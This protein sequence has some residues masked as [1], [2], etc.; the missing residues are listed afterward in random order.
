MDYFKRSVGALKGRIARNKVA[1]RL[2]RPRRKS[3]QPDIEKKLVQ[4]LSRSRIPSWR[5]LKYIGRFLS[6][7]E[8]MIIGS[9][10][11]VFVASALVVTARLYQNNVVALPAFGGSYTEALTGAPKFINPLY[12]SLSTVDSDI[13]SLVYGGLLKRN[14]DAQLVPDI[15]EHYTVSDDKKTYTFTLR[16]GIRWHDGEILNA[17]DVIF[18]IAAIKDPA[19]QSPLRGSFSGITASKADERTVVFTLAEPYPAFTSLLTVGILPAHV[20]KDIP[21]ES[22]SLAANNLKP[23]GS[24]PYQFA[25]LAKDADTG[26]VRVYE[27]RAFTDYFGNNAHIQRIVFRFNP[28][29]QEGVRTLNEGRA[30]GLDYLPASG[31]EQLVAKKSY[32][33]RYLPQPQVTALFFNQATTGALEN[34]TV[35]QALA[36]ATNKQAITEN[37]PAFTAIDTPILPLF[38]DYY[39]SDIT[40]YA[41]DKTKARTMLEEAGWKLTEYE[42][43][44][45]TS[46][47][48]S[49]EESTDEQTEVPAGTWYKKGSQ[50]LSVTITTADQEDTRAAAET[51]AE[52]WRALNVA[53]TVELVDPAT[54]QGDVIRPRTY[55]ALLYGYLAGA[56]PDPYPFWHSTQTG[57]Q[58]LNLANFKNAEVDEAIETARSATD[59]EKRVTAYHELQELLATHVPAVF[60]YSHA[61]PYVQSN[62]VS[63]F[64]T[65]AIIEPSNRF[66]G[67]TKWYVE[68]KKRL[69]IFQ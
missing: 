4:S 46:T 63:G 30:D 35:R 43:S 13:A 14:D 57:A 50:W 19:Y 59:E 22:A 37:N 45:A 60:L 55:E 44:Q 38:G 36:Y 32:H 16:D 12:A 68:T 11:V 65:N 25:S 26:T 49:T 29:F 7:R 23:I 66:S 41:F 47:A 51:I 10:A 62:A 54:I 39:N 61:Y 31:R 27:L 67:V 28:T 64:T 69:K 34:Q 52:Q 42:P 58:G 18:T 9:A 53:A 2:L 56:D 1:G 5:Q 8:K 20:W 6:N 48:T 33:F 17:D 40:R 15:T 24:G 3:A 21:P